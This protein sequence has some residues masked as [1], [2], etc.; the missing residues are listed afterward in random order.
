MKVKERGTQTLVK[1]EV[2]VTDKDICIMS[3]ILERMEEARSKCLVAEEDV[4]Y[5]RKVFGL[6]DEEYYKEED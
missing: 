6:F 3:E 1:L 2:L 4:E 5:M